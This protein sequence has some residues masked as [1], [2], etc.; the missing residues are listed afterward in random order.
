MH[1]K[2]IIIFCLV[3]FFTDTMSNGLNAIQIQF[4]RILVKKFN[5]IGEVNK[6]IQC[7]NINEEYHYNTEVHEN[8]RVNDILHFM[9][10]YDKAGD[11]IKLPGDQKEIMRLDKYDLDI[12]FHH[13]FRIVLNNN[14]I[15]E[16]S[17]Y[18]SLIDSFEYN[19]LIKDKN[20][21]LNWKFKVMGE[22]TYDIG[23][24]LI[25]LVRLQ[26]Q[27]YGQRFFKVEDETRIEHFIECIIN[28]EIPELDFM[29]LINNTF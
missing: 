11:G 3:C 7:F 18:K 26:A 4:L 16:F 27:F 25:D 10:Q 8:K 5:K 24:V 15:I 22:G 14:G 6:V 9:Y 29:L 13:F 1:L 20:E 23:N 12:V 28:D 17:E 2:T 21:L 19:D